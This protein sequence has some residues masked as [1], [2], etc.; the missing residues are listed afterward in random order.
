[1]ARTLIVESIII[2]LYAHVYPTILDFRQIVAPNVLWIPIV[3]QRWL[4]SAIN[5]R[6]HAMEHADRMHIAPFST[7]RLI[8][9]AMMDLPAIHTVDAVKLFSVSEPNRIGLNSVCESLISLY[10]SVFFLLGMVKC[11][12]RNVQLIF[13]D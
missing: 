4:V 6:V 3:Q 2:K 10:F 7:T 12:S 5:V 13:R 8:V 11:T 9:F 1:M